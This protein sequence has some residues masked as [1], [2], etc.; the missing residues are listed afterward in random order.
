MKF[1]REIP[2]EYVS[3]CHHTHASREIPIEV[4]DG[5]IGCFDLS[6]KKENAAARR[7][8]KTWLKSMVYQIEKDSCLFLVKMT[9]KFEN[10]VKSRGIHLL[11]HRRT[12][13]KRLLPPCAAAHG[14]DKRTAFRRAGAWQNL[15][16]PACY[17]DE[18]MHKTDQSMN[19]EH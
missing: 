8:A 11:F 4:S 13:P 2:A 6:F 5:A 19:K 10:H 7:A 15:R 18:L 3:C 16:R 14:F 1:F 9:K 12:V 17:S